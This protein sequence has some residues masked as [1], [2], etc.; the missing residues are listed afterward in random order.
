MQ[1]PTK[2]V[3]SDLRTRCISHSGWS[4]HLGEVAGEV[5]RVPTERFGRIH[6][7]PLEVG[8]RF[9]AFILTLPGRLGAPG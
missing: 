8:E 9:G 7:D 3:P 4:F 2:A 6:D 5:V 1:S